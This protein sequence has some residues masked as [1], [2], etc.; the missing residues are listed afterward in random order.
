MS[1]VIQARCRVVQLAAVVHAEEHAHA[2]RNASVLRMLTIPDSD[3]SMA[4]PNP[5]PASTISVAFKGV[6]WIW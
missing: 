1:F 3:R 6:R 2:R 5:M 4:R